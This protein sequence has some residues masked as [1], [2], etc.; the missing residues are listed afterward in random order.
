MHG[1]PICALWTATVLLALVGGCGADPGPTASPAQTIPDPTRSAPS[2]A[3]TIDVLASPPPQPATDAPV[4]QAA[5]GRPYTAVAILK[6]MNAMSRT[7]LPDPLVQ[8]WVAEALAKR[9]WTYDGRPYSTVSIAGRCTEPAQQCHIQLVGL[10]A[11][12]ADPESADAIWVDLRMD[13]RTVLSGGMGGGGYPQSLAPGIEASVRSLASDA[14]GD[15][16]L[17]GMAWL[18]E[19]RDSDA[20]RLVFG[21]GTEEGDPQIEIIF[22]RATGKILS[23]TPIDTLGLVE[24]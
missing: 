19:P 24:D 13:D 4:P 23:V 11:F 5:H 14:I 2:A 12:A 9:V 16:S 18:A 6:W 1:R 3:P 15:R 21:Y 20:F 10:P 22:D 17:L 7:A 8:D